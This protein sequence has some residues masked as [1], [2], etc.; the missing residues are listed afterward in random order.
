MRS[1]K[2]FYL[3][4]PDIGNGEILL[5]NLCIALELSIKFLNNYLALTAQ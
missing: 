3:K 4:I 1:F 5:A 2:L